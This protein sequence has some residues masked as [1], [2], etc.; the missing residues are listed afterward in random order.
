VIVGGALS[1]QN[2]QVQITL[3]QRYLCGKKLTPFG[4][5]RSAGF[6]EGGTA[7]EMAIGIE[8]VMD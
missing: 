6:L 4:K 2:N 1:E 3:R 7:G 5:C 8:M